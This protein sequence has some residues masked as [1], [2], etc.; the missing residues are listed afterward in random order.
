MAPPT[1]SYNNQGYPF[2]QS[3]PAAT[4]QSSQP[5]TTPPDQHPTW[6]YNT[7]SS[8]ADRDNSFPPTVLP[9]IHSFGRANAPSSI[10]GPGVSSGPGVAG[11]PWNS[12]NRDEAEPPYR[13]WHTEPSYPG[14]GSAPFNA[15]SLDPALRGSSSSF[16]HPDSRESWG[17]IP[18]ISGRSTQSSFANAGP[19]TQPDNQVYASASYTQQPPPPI[20][21]SPYTQNASSS[22]STIPPLPRHSYTRTLVGPLSANAC[23]LMDEHRKPGIFFLFQDLSVRTEGTASQYTHSFLFTHTCLPPGTFRLRLRL[24]NVGA[25]VCIAH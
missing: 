18:N 1:H 10:L 4:F 5:Y 24:M 15:S 11:D 17:S 12:S 7:S 9:S 6:G 14:M 19:S 22:A 20:Y 3:I 2:N 21:P 8:H 25:Y 16:S 23:R 13:G